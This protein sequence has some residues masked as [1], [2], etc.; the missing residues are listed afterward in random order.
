MPY[1]LFISP[2]TLKVLKT[3]DSNVKDSIKTK[4]KLLTLDP[5]DKIGHR[6]NI[7]RD[8]KGHMV[9]IDTILTEEDYLSLHE[10]RKEKAS[11]VLTS[12]ENLKTE[13]GM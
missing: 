4:L 12:H 1:E 3:L 5:F 13:L 11:D 7:Y 6:K 8:I 2:S 9:D 10:Y